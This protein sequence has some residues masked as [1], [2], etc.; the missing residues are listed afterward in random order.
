MNRPDASGKR[1]R[2]SPDR[3]GI[4]RFSAE[5]SSTVCYK[6]QYCKWLRVNSANRGAAEFF[7]LNQRNF[8]AEQGNFSPEQ[9]NW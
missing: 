2:D 7:A 4:L 5:N 3:G 6:T 1:R 8:L 9:R